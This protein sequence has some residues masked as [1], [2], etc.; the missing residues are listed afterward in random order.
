[1]SYPLITQ[2]GLKSNTLQGE[3]VFV[4]GVGGGIGYETARALLWLGAYVIIA[5]IASA[6]GQ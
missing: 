6:S 4:T 3:T 1:M 5:E 2:L